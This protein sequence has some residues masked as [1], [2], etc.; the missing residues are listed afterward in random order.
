MD[1]NKYKNTTN[2]NT[3]NQNL[4]NTST[5]DT[6]LT[7]IDKLISSKKADYTIGMNSLSGYNS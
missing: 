5:W 3:R 4:K 1:Y 2:Q 6:I 7:S